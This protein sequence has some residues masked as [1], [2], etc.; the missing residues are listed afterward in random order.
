M[1]EL[2]PMVINTFDS[3]GINFSP[4]YFEAGEMRDKQFIVVG[5]RQIEITKEDPVA[6]FVLRERE[7]VR[8][9][10]HYDVVRLDDPRVSINNVNFS[11]IRLDS[12]KELM[13]ET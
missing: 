7:K 12:Y 10:H 1:V 8:I 6:N 3:K 5:K 2:E 4:V 9:T 11:Y 13:V